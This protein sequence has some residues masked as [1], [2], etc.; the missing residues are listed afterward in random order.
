M[1][2]QRFLYGNHTLAESPVTAHCNNPEVFYHQKEFRTE[3]FA[4]FKMFFF[5]L[6]TLRVKK[7]L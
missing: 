1:F 7:K 5:V 6:L 4:D 2:T 3:E